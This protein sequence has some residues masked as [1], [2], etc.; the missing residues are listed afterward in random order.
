[1]DNLKE[2]ISMC[3]KAKEIQ[4]LWEPSG[5]DWYVFDYRGTT[6]T[7][8]EFEKSIW[9]DNDKQWQRI[10]ILCYRPSSAKNF[11]IS[12]NGDTSHVM[13]AKDMTKE[14]AIWLPRQD[15]LQA[16]VI[17]IGSVLNI[18]RLSEFC[19]WI[20]TTGGI[21]SFYHWEYKRQFES[22]EQFWLA[23][24]MKKK[25]QKIWNGTGWIKEN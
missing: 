21:D 25:Y 5:G 8:K 19:L 11:F 9:E 7:F 10:E 4:E 15:Q 23:F 3:Q 16:M 6:G 12:T 17:L 18:P 22:M 14:R 20:T 24:V 2:Y 13:S 1:M